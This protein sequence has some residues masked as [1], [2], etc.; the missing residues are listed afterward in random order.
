LAAAVG[1]VE[2]GDRPCETAQPWQE[3]AEAVEAVEAV[4]GCRL[5]DLVSGH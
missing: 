3:A 4:G 2:V 5:D 1:E